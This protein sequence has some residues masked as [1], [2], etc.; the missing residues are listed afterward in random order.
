MAKE[1]VVQMW[2]NKRKQWERT[3]ANGG[4]LFIEDRA[5]EIADSLHLAHP[6]IMYRAWRMRKKGSRNRADSS[7]SSTS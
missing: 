6:N 2:S 4:E 7:G 3:L 5:E 1:Y